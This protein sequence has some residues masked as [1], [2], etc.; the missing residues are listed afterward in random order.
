MENN[1][2]MKNGTCTSCKGDAM[3]CHCW[4]MHHHSVLRVLVALVIVGF[5][6]IAGMKLGELKA[7]L[8]IFYTG[9][10]SA[11]V[12]GGRGDMGMMR[13][14]AYGMAGQTTGRTTTIVVPA[15]PTVPATTPAAQ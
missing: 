2:E 8:A 9:N 7:E 13:G 10:H 3:H 4:G 14:G 1:Q 5:V 15:T 6:F 11:M 12:T